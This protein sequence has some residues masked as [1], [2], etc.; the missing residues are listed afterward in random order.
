MH[1][2]PIK[3][4]VDMMKLVNFY[5]S[6]WQRYNKRYV[7]VE[8]LFAESANKKSKYCNSEVGK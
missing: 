7:S 2:L 3:E 5:L 4:Q 1:Y 6:Y 8:Q